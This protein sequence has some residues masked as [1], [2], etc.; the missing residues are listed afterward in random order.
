MIKIG[1][2]RHS[3]T[4]GKYGKAGDQTGGEV[5][6]TDWYDG[7]WLYVFR[8][9]KKDTAESIASFIEGACNN[10]LIGYSQDDRLSLYYKYRAYGH[11]RNI[12]EKCNCDCSSLVACACIFAGIII[13]PDIYTGIE[14]KVL[15]GTGAFN[16]LT[17]DEYL[18]TYQNLLRGDILLKS[19]H[20]AGALGDPEKI[21]Q[22]KHEC[23]YKDNNLS[24]YYRAAAT[25][26]MRDYSSLDADV[27]T[28]IKKGSVVR[29]YG[30]YNLDSRNIKWLYCRYLA[31]E[32][33]YLGFISELCLE[34]C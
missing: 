19:G 30:Y 7:D 12:K 13:D 29:C 34:R 31:P 14:K 23:R 18:K 16:T 22:S 21:K 17:G 9:K 24:G 32:G 6:I 28:V 1:H 25:C 20:T 4:G 8:P 15:E 33:E 10:D 26:N 5:Q 27:L 3:E 11:P 2:A